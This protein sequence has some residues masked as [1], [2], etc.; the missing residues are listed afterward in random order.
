[1]TGKLWE[2]LIITFSIDISETEFWDQFD[3]SKIPNNWSIADVEGSCGDLSV[4][5]SIEDEFSKEDVQAVKCHLE[6]FVEPCKNCGLMICQDP[7]EC[8]YQR[9]R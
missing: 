2:E 3:H 8:S 9:D 5:F 7:I 6:S 1:M 4:S